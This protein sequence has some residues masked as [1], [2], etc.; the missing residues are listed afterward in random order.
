MVSEAFS[1]NGE[2]PCGRT[3]KFGQPGQLSGLLL[4]RP[5]GRA[6]AP[7]YFVRMG[8]GFIRQIGKGVRGAKMTK[9]ALRKRKGSRSPLLAAEMIRAAIISKTICDCHN[10]RRMIVE[11][12]CMP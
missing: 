2:S 8:K 1:R 7:V 3:A 5:L 4:G 9:P 12:V 11:Y 10:A 6:T